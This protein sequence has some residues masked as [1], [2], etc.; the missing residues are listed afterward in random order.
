MENSA[1]LIEL[2]SKNKVKLRFPSEVIPDELSM[3]PTGLLART[4]QN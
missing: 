2:S 4:V 1:E 3:A